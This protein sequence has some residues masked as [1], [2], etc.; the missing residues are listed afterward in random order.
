MAREDVK[1]EIYKLLEEEKNGLTENEIVNR[2]QNPS[3]S[4]SKKRKLVNDAISVLLDEGRIRNEG[5]EPYR[6]LVNK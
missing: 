4:P 6:Y 1:E 3:I 5:K 2:W